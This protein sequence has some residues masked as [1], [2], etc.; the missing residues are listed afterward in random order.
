MNEIVFSE[1]SKEIWINM[2]QQNAGIQNRWKVICLNC[3]KWFTFKRINSKFTSNSCCYFLVISFK[4]AYVHNVYIPSFQHNILWYKWL[5]QQI[6]IGKFIIFFS[7]F[8]CIIFMY[9]I[10]VL[11]LFYILRVHW[12]IY[13]FTSWNYICIQKARA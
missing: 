1:I 9:L 6:F 4:A 11:L 3:F 10:F 7:E 12:W 13:L 8:K 5:K 2:H